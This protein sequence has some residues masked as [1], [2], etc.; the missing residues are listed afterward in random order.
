MLWFSCL[1]L[2]EVGLGKEK[3]IEEELREWVLVRKYQTGN[4]AKS[5]SLLFWLI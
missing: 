5:I 1:H 4:L 3:E 2:T